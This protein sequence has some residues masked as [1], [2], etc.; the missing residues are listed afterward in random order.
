MD[1]QKII[2]DLLEK[3]NVDASL[4]EKFKKDP[5]ETVKGLLATLNL[6]LDMDQINA[7]VEGLKTKLNIEDIVKEGGG[8][9]DKIK[10]FFGGK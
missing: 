9:L 2:S 5:L 1:I 4:L 7:V 8:L 6:N 3:F 10:S